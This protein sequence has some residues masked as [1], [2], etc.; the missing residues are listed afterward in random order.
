MKCQ[1]LINSR[2]KLANIIDS[3]HY[4]KSTYNWPRGSLLLRVLKLKVLVF[5]CGN[6]IFRFSLSFFRWSYLCSRISPLC[7]RFRCSLTCWLLEAFQTGV[8]SYALTSKAASCFSSSHSAFS[9]QLYKTEAGK[10]KAREKVIGLKSGWI[11]PFVLY[12]KE[13]LIVLE[14]SDITKL[15]FI[16]SLRIHEFCFLHENAL[17]YFSVLLPEECRILTGLC[18]KSFKCQFQC[19]RLD[20]AQSIHVSCKLLLWIM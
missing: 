20:T 10:A 4:T 18:S 17:L 19:F 1:V 5:S 11:F 16:I 3:F 13:K 12:C 9:P 15:I 2:E 14:R 8:Y 6:V 7:E